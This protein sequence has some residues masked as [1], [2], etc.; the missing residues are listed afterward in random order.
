M[1]AC[2]WSCVWVARPS[3]PSSTQHEGVPVMHHNTIEDC[4]LKQASYGVAGDAK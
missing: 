3:R 4:G 2:D 1:V